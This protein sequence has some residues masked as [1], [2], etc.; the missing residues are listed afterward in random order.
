MELT[1]VPTTRSRT[2]K[3]GGATAAL[4]ANKLE[5]GLVMAK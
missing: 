3:P 5:V 2:A 1:G 4:T